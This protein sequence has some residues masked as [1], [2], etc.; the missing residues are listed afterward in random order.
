VP[1]VTYEIQT[2]YA[3]GVDPNATSGYGVGT[4]STDTGEQK[5]LRFHEGSHGTVFIREV[6]ANI[7]ANKYPTWQGQLG[8]TQ[9]DFEQHLND[10]RAGVKAFQDMLAA[11]VETST[12]AVDCVGKTIEQYHQENHTITTVRCNP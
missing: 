1:D 5:K 11:A 2:H 10:F 12:Q 8:Q 7:A 6:K 9:A 3:P 4:R